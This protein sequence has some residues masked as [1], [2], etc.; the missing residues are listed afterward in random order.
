MKYL[1]RSFF[2]WLA[3]HVLRR[4]HPQVIGVA[5][6]VGKTAT[7]DAVAA[8]V[9]PDQARV[10]KTEGNF[11]A[12][13]GV[14]VT[15]ISGGGPRRGIFGWA[16]VALEGL[17]LLAKTKPYPGVLILELGTDHPGDLR[18]LLDLTHPSIGI[19]TSTAPEHLEFFGDVDGVIAEESLIVRTLPKTGTAIVNIDDER[20]RALVGSLSSHVM[21]YGWHADATVRAESFTITRSERGLPDGM[22]VKIAIEGSVIPVALPRVLGKHQAAPLLAAVAAG[23][24][25]GQDISVTIQNISA[26]QPPPGRMRLFEGL[27]GSLLIDDSY[28]A[29][30]EAMTAALATLI[31]L[32]IP[33]KKYAVL[34]Q[35]SE[36]GSAATDWHDQIGQSITPKTIHS[37]ITVGP[38]AE[39]IGQAAVSVGFPSVRVINVPTAEAAAALL[40]TKLAP[41]DAVLLK[42]SRYASRLERA[43]QILLADPERDGRQLVQGH[44]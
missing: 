14:P 37:L 13:A 38:L 20:N 12:E 1:A 31:E 9:T 8:A 16:K 23:R 3:S 41:G 42:G 7:K 43:V 44:G 24:A 29:S 27:E 34:G 28:N 26:Y 2:R 39:R 36:L 4:Y 19:L 32:D 17:V 33:G 21:T 35:M 5:G 10:R 22:V 30:P 11:N 6:S 25:L 40:Q 18:R 15:I